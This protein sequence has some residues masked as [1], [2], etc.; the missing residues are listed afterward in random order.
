MLTKPNAGKALNQR[1]K[2]IVQCRNGL[3][4]WGERMIVR[5]R[6]SKLEAESSRVSRVANRDNIRDEI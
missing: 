6:S 1:K 2:D 3:T 4:R 5:C